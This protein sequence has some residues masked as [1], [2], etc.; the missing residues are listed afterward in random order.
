MNQNAKDELLKVLWNLEV[1]NTEALLAL[2]EMHHALAEEVIS[3]SPASADRLSRLSQIEQT[4]AA[5]RDGRKLALEMKKL[6]DS[7]SISHKKP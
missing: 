3:L 2:F 5:L 1:M 7:L 6:L 4:L